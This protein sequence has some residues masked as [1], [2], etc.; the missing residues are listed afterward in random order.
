[1]IIEFVIKLL[2]FNG[3]QKVLKI[4]HPVIS[5]VSFLGNDPKVSKLFVYRLY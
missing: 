3:D 4:L 1:M 5:I 2:Y